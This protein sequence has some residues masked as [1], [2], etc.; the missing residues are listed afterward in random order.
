MANGI[1]L[2]QAGFEVYTANKMH[3]LVPGPSPASDFD[4]LQYSKMVRK[5]LGDRVTCNDVRG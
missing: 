1:V 4:C 5:G 3:S 2:A